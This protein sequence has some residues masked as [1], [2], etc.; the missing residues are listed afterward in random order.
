MYC[1]YLANLEALGVELRYL[2]KIENLKKNSDFEITFKNEGSYVLCL[3]SF[4][5]SKIL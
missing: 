2:S 4:W 5:N 1:K 3:S